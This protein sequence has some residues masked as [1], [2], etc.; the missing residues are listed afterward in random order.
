MADYRFELGIDANAVLNAQTSEYYMP[1]GFIQL[2]GTNP[3]ILASAMSPAIPSNSNIEFYIFDITNYTSSTS[4][5]FS[6]LTLSIDSLPAE[7][8][9]GPL[10]SGTTIPELNQAPARSTYFGGTFSAWSSGQFLVSALTDVVSAA[11]R[12]LL[13]FTVEVSAST[14]PLVMTFSTDPEMVVGPDG[15]SSPEPLP[16]PPLQSAVEAEASR[17]SSL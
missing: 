16:L 7:T 15:L 3:A 17:T 10:S 9:S 11:T 6:N 12:F 8:T 4:T 14:T 13:S 5:V 1:F 2:Q